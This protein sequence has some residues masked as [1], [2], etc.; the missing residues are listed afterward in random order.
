LW[1]SLLK[2]DRQSNIF[3]AIRLFMASFLVPDSGTLHNEPAV[4]NGRRF[5]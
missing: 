3:L 4:R 2:A 1:G 5:L